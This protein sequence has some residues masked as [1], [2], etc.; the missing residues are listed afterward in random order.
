MKILDYRARINRTHLFPLF[1]RLPLDVT[2]KK[3]IRHLHLERVKIDKQPYWNH[4]S[5]LM[6]FYEE[7]D[8]VHVQSIDARRFEVDIIEKEVSMDL[9]NIKAITCINTYNAETQFMLGYI[10]YDLDRFVSDVRLEPEIGITGTCDV[11]MFF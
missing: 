11:L 10:Y 6:Y 3:P 1:E 2:L 7:F 4:V 5:K 9:R 8:D